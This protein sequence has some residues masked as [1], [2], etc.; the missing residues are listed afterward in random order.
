MTQNTIENI[1][2]M[3]RTNKSL[4][5]NNKTQLL[6]L[7]AALKPEMAKFS[8]VQAEHAESVAGFIERSTHEALRQQKNPSLLKIAIDGLSASVK[9]F[10][11]SHPQLVENVNFIASALSNI[12]I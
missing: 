6:N 12:G 8:D 7:L 1:E 9:G 3:I 2:E 11:A 5:E 10:E 4:N